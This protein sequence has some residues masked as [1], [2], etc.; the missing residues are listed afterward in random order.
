MS[1]KNKN[2]IITGGSRGIG[3]AIA[4]LFL[5]KGANVFFTYVN[6]ESVEYDESIKAYQV[7]SKDYNSVKYFISEFVKQYKEIDVLVNN[8]GIRRDKSLLLMEKEDWDNV[9]ETNLNGA[10]HITKAV[11][12][13]MLKSKRGRITNISSVSGIN[14]I[15]GQ[16]NYSASKAGMIGF[17]KALAKEV[18]TYGI[19]VNAI[20]PGPVE[21]KMLD[22]LKKEYIERLLNNVPI[23]RL[24]SPGEVAMV[25]N[26]LADDELSPSYLTGQVIS[27]DGG[28]GL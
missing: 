8:A 5:S 1:L 26:F 13:H 4:L 22:G 23:N 20:A 3:K 17:T 19:C 7:D 14:G 18:A 6:N 2:I 9:I 27:L 15:A 21:T 11:I 25:A 12:P 24:C 16:T 10:F 28:M